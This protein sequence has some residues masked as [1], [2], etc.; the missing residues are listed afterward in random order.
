MNPFVFSREAIRLDSMRGPWAHL[1]ANSQQSSQE[2]EI[3]T[4][5]PKNT[6]TERAFFSYVS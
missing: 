1:V 5:R 3:L 2:K 4:S 6:L